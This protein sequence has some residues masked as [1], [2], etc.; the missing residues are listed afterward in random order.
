MLLIFSL[1]TASMFPV[2]YTWQP[3]VK[4]YQ[5]HTYTFWSPHNLF[6]GKFPNK[7]SF[8]TFKRWL[9]RGRIVAE[10]ELSYKASTTF[11]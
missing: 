9:L 7:C 2:I 3:D 10:I 6:F 4:R 11:F 5:T 1:T 8:I